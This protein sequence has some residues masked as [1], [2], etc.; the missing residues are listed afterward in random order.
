MDDKGRE[1]VSKMEMKRKQKEEAQKGSC[2]EWLAVSYLYF[3]GCYAE[4]FVKVP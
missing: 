4:Q 1:R 3:I 2:C